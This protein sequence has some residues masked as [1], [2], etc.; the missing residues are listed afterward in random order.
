MYERCL[1]EAERV[2]GARREVLVP[3]KVIWEEVVKEGKR[4]GFEVASLADFTAMLEGD[5]RFEIIPAHKESDEQEELLTEEGVEEGVMESLGF[6]P[7]DRVRLRTLA[8]AKKVVEKE[9]E[10]EEEIG[11][12]RRKWF[13]VTVKPVAPAEGSARKGPR[14]PP[15][16]PRAARGARARAKRSASKKPSRRSRR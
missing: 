7:E 5:R 12:I 13:A 11:S 15:T 1:N 4:E 3:V 9:S 2:L 16:T 14:Q 6:F 8:G 10:E